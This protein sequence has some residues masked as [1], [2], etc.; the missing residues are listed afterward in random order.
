[1]DAHV[2]VALV[3]AEP[4][5]LAMADINMARSKVIWFAGPKRLGCSLRRVGSEATSGAIMMV[6]AQKGAIA[7]RPKSSL[8]QTDPATATVVAA[9]A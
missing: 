6:A 7:D 9:A 1:M 5:R 4:R 8:N 2:A 3:G